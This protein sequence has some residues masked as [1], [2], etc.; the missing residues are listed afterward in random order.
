[1]TYS[2]RQNF[3]LYRHREGDLYVKLGKIV[4]GSTKKELVRYRRMHCFS[5]LVT[6]EI[7]FNKEF[8]YCGDVLTAAVY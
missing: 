2:K 5:E 7:I 4:S 8:T 6:S 1:M 3:E